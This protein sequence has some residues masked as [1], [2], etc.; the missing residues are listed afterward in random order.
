MWW[1]RIV[2]GFVTLG[3]FIFYLVNGEWLSWILL[4]GIL[5]LPWFSLV[6]SLPAMILTKIRLF[7]PDKVSMNSAV[8]VQVEI[9][10]PLPVPPVKWNFL[11]YE[12]YSGK[13]LTFAGN[14]AFLADHCGSIRVSM[15]KSFVY[16]YLG[17][18]RLPK[19]KKEEKA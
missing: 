14:E 7:C 16:D 8:N 12:V 15:K 11:A 2:Y 3:A 19:T 5:F 6:L 17:L 10:C 4:L 1:R 9:C 18:V 13:R